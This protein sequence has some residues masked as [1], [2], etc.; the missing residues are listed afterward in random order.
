MLK[1]KLLSVGDRMPAWVNLGTREY[2]D[3]VRGNTCV[4]LIEIPALKRG[5]HADI[6]RILANEGKAMLKH[7]A[8]GAHLVCLDRPVKLH[9]SFVVADKISDWQRLGQ[10]VVFTIGGPEGIDPSL[11]ARADETWSLSKMT[12][13][14]Y[15]ARVMLA[16][17]LYRAWSINQGLPYHR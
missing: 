5:K 3:R 6:P 16:E 7:I 17:Q 1:I 12:F 13:S 8:P 11:L 2:I 14:H 10:P 4:E 9:D 15:V